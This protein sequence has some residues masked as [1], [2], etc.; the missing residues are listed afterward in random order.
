LIRER[1]T[2]NRKVIRMAHVGATAKIFGSFD[3]NARLIEES[4]SVSLRNRE[5][6]SGDSI[7]IEGEHEEAVAAAAR[8]IEYL[9]GLCPKTDVITDQS[10]QY[11]VDMVKNGE[12][13][14]LAELGG[15]CICVTMRGKPIK[16]KTV[17]QKQYVDLIRKNTIVLGVGPA[18]TGKT[19]LAVAMAV[20]ALREKQVNRIILTRPAIEAGEKLGFLPGDLQ[21]KIDPYLRPLY[22]ALHEMMGTENYQ[23]QVEK[24][25]I[26]IA[27]LAYMRGR[28]LD[29][30]F[31][32][33]DEAQNATPEQMKMFLTR[34]GFNSKAVVTGDLTQTDLPRGQK[35]GLSTAVKIL[36]DIDDIGIHYFTDRDVV[37]HRL[38]QKIILA[39]EKYDREIAR[40]DAEKKQHMK[41]RAE[42]TGT[43]E[44]NKGGS[45]K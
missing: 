15:E 33:L 18:G 21:S 12:G 35:S 39:Y 38:V 1:G 25:V 5:S 43:H 14:T 44:S 27:P 7:V 42:R 3:S 29:D 11:A 34:L 36:S 28:T 37:R 8:C 9:H 20:R 4:F 30:S 23:K 13:E 32:I 40:K 22:D 45:F 19:F 31:I 41:I 26:E 16:A 17:G 2:M 6:E 24:G 10:V